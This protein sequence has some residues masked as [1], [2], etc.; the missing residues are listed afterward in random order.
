VLDFLKRKRRDTRP[1][2]DAP[3]DT[4]VAYSRDTGGEPDESAA[5]P[6]ST[7]GTTP[8]EEFVGRAEGQDVGYAG[9][10]GAERRA[11]AGE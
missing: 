3:Q 8:N 4:G 6:N 5:D 7:T 2:M 10:T 11:E 9:E 1:E